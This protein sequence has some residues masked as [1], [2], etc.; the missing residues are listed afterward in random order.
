MLE[1]WILTYLSYVPKQAKEKD[2]FYLTPLP[3]KPVDP[4]KPWYTLTPVGKNKLNG[5]LKDMC[6]EAG[7]AKDF[8]NH[9]LRAYGATI[10]F[11][12]KVPEKLIQMRTGHKSLEALRSYERTSESQLMDVSHVVCNMKN[13]PDVTCSEIIPYRNTSPN[14][15]L[16]SAGLVETKSSSNAVLPLFNT[17]NNNIPNIVITG[18]NFT[19]CNVSL[20]RKFDKASTDKASIDELL[21]GLTPE[22][23]FDD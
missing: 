17:A 9:S 3:Q 18:C 8:N 10:L 11:Q 6:A 4:T 16:S 2:V 13:T 20:C 14:D 1:Y 5:M 19:N 22:Q 7:L 23:L 15:Q 12:A 21:K